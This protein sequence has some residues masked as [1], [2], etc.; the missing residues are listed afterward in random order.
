MEA[1]HSFTA[2][3]P[4]RLLLYTVASLLTVESSLQKVTC[5]CHFTFDILI[6]VKQF[7]FAYQ[8]FCTFKN[9]DYPKFLVIK[10]ISLK[11]ENYRKWFW[12]KIFK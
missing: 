10:N 1:F 12:V 11:K 4:F 7:V 9:N 6:A 2:I 3:Y 8:N 5:S